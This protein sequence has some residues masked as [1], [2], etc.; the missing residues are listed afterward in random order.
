[1]SLR[2]SGTER[3]IVSRSMRRPPLAQLSIQQA[4]VPG[5]QLV[6]HRVVALDVADLGDPLAVGRIVAAPEAERV[7][8][9]VVAVDVHAELVDPLRQQVGQPAC[10][11]PGR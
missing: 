3:M 5:Q 8:V 2:H 7:D 9:E 4:G 1:M 6:P 11:P 10:G